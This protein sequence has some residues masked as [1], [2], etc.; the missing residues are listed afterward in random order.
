M[1]NVKPLFTVM[2]KRFGLL[3]L[4]GKTAL[5]VSERIVILAVTL[6]ARVL[7]APLKSVVGIVTSS[8]EPGGV[9]GATPLTSQLL[10]KLKFALPVPPDTPVPFH[11]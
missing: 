6:I 8:D 2:V 7:F 9:A 10:A 3:E 4:E 11:T 1:D 5:H